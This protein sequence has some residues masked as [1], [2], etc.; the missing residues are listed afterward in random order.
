MKCTVFVHFLMWITVLCKA[1]LVFDRDP[2]KELKKYI[3]FACCFLKCGLFPYKMLVV[4]WVQYMENRS[5]FLMLTG[6]QFCSPK[7]EQTKTTTVAVRIATSQS[8]SLDPVPSEHW[9]QSTLLLGS[10]MCGPWT[11]GHYAQVS[12]LLSVADGALVRCLPLDQ[13]FIFLDLCL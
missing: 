3:D 1:D 4:L 5:W 13:S 12:M 7:W 8:I 11:R 6:S 10:C 9:Q 2:G